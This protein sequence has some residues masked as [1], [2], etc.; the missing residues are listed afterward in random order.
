LSPDAKGVFVPMTSE[1]LKR[2]D[3][4]RARLGLSRGGALAAVYD[5][6]GDAALDAAQRRGAAA[7]AEAATLAQELS[8]LVEALSAL[9]SAWAARAR[10]RQSIGVHTNQLAKLCNVLRIALGDGRAIDPA[11]VERLASA[12]EAIDRRLEKQVEEERADDALLAEVRDHLTQLRTGAARSWAGWS[13]A[14][15]RSR[16]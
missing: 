6:L 12:L 8:P 14:A 7:A 9:E 11:D 16:S 10:Q 3:A 4:D 15:S 13:R 5:N 2:L 1:R